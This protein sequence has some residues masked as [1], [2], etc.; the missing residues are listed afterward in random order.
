MA[1][2]DIRDV[3]TVPPEGLNVVRIK[4]MN[5]DVFTCK[6]IYV[7]LTSKKNCKQQ[8]MKQ[9]TIC[10]LSNHNH[11]FEENQTIIFRNRSR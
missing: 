5:E 8:N 7:L 9:N 6:H 11:V 1:A 10:I 3:N 2:F 4:Q